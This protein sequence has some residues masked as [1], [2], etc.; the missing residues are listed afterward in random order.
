MEAQSATV[1]N[2]T[3]EM[4]AKWQIDDRVYYEKTTTDA[5]FRKIFNASGKD[6]KQMTADFL[7][8]ILK[9]QFPDRDLSTRD[10]KLQSSDINSEI[11]SKSDAE[12]DATPATKS[13]A[14]PQN[15]EVDALFSAEVDKFYGE[16]HNT[17]TIS[18]L[19]EMQVSKQEFG[20][21]LIHY[22]SIELGKQKINL[23]NGN[24]PNPV[25]AVG[26]CMWSGGKFFTRQESLSSYSLDAED[27]PSSKS[28]STHL[29]TVFLDTVKRYGIEDNLRLKARNSLKKKVVAY[30]TKKADISSEELNAAYNKLSDREKSVYEWLEFVS[31]GHL[32]TPADV[33]QLTNEHVRK[34]YNMNIIHSNDIARIQETMTLDEAK[35]AK[36]NL[37]NQLRETAKSWATLVQNK[38]IGLKDVNPEEVRDM[39]KKILAERKAEVTKLPKET[40]KPKSKSQKRK[41]GLQ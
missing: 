14:K 2:D 25:V 32:M 11:R 20:T 5:S 41:P 6:A 15:L 30:F 28:T 36:K 31:C 9:I 38:T 12:H 16:E 35:E 3:K 4:P 22:A 10:V 7:T 26:L 13:T 19:V 18:M 34:A 33:E 23:D 27:T 21:R 1:T 24:V 8:S 39:V 29:Q 40:V 17:R 37:E